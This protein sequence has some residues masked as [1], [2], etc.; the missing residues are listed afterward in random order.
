ML[1]GRSAVFHLDARRK[2]AMAAPEFYHAMDVKGRL[3]PSAPVPQCPQCP[4]RQRRLNT[5]A[6]EKT[7]II[8]VTPDGRSY[9]W[10]IGLLIGLPLVLLPGDIVVFSV[11]VRL[12]GKAPCAANGWCPWQARQRRRRAARERPKGWPVSAPGRRCASWQGLRPLPARRALPGTL[13]DSTE[14]GNITWKEHKARF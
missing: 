11:R 6:Q 10:L 2:L 1:T 4:Q 7:M 3:A 9:Y 8:E 14:Y 13:T 12:V 5:M